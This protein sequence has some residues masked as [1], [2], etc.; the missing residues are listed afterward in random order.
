MTDSAGDLHHVGGID[1][2][3]AILDAPFAQIAFRVCQLGHLVDKL[4]AYS[5]LFFKQRPDGLADLAHGGVARVFVVRVVKM[6]GF[7]AQPASHA[8]FTIG[9][10]PGSGFSLKNPGDHIFDA[11]RGQPV[12]SCLNARIIDFSFG[13]MSYGSFH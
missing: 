8:Y 11:F 3:G 2:K 5:S 1:S 6:A 10:K 4:R 12:H 7:A 13:Y 9:L